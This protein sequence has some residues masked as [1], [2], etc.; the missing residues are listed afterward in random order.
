MVEQGDLTP[1]RLAGDLEELIAHPGR[2]AAA[3]TAAR[4]V[5]RPNAVDNLA[6]LV[7]KVA[8]EKRAKGKTDT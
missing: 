4:S 2:T 1:E 8:G 3:A 7:E 6:D 5:G